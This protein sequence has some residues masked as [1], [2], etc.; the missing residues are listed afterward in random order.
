MKSIVARSGGRSLVVTVSIAVVIAN[1][2]RSV[3]KTA[4]KSIK[5]ECHHQAAA[6]AGGG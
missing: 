2:H 5:K 1:D 3:N 6:A 4:Q